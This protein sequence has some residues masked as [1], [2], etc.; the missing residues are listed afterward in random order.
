[1][2][3]I[4]FS[5]HAEDIKIPIYFDEGQLNSIL[6]IETYYNE[7]MLKKLKEFKGKNKYALC[8][9]NDMMSYDLG[10]KKTCL[11]IINFLN[12]ISIDWDIINISSNNNEIWAAQRPLNTP[13]SLEWKYQ[14]DYIGNN[15]IKKIY[16]LP[17]YTTKLKYYMNTSCPAYVVNLK[18]IDRINEVLLPLKFNNILINFLENLDKINLF[19]SNSNINKIQTFEDKSELLYNPVIFLDWYGNIDDKIFLD[20]IF[21]IKIH[22]SL[23]EGLTDSQIVNRLIFK[24]NQKIIS[25]D[26]IKIKWY[27][28]DCNYN[29]ENKLVDIIFSLKSSLKS[30]LKRKNFNKKIDISLGYLCPRTDKK[31]FYKKENIKLTTD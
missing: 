5:E 28:D 21:K 7:Q 29:I 20:N 4:L 25:P 3:I 16:T 12:D 11:F 15:I 14:L 31:V 9:N 8:I 18:N 23:I 13:N 27:N 17:S 24:I 19:F 1:M 6:N 22:K 30:L 10:M 26:F 2:E